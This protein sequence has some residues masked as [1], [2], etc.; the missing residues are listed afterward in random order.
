MALL[1]QRCDAL[2]VWRKFIS[3]DGQD[4]VNCA[5]FRNEGQILSSDLIMEADDLAWARW[6]AEARHYTYVA[7]GKVASP[8]PGYCFKMARWRVSGRNKDGRLTILERV[9]EVLS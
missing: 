6:P 5:I 3:D 7:D 1:T 2:F 4:G 8:N 9:L